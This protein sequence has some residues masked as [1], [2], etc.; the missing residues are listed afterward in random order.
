[1]TGKIQIKC[2][3]VFSVNGYLTFAPLSKAPLV[4]NIWVFLCI[5][6]SILKAENTLLE[7]I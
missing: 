5:I 1:M 7:C 3:D 6:S 2:M 4:H